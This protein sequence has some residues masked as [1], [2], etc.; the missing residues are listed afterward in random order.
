MLL[1]LVQRDGER[2]VLQ[3]NTSELSDLGLFLEQL[4]RY[5]GSGLSGHWTPLTIKIT[6]SQSGT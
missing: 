1:Y 2:P 3:D 5:N 4:S 6:R